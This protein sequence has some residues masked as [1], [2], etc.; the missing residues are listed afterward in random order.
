M[1]SLKNLAGQTI[2][3]GLSNIAAKL[4]NVLL[5]PL[6]TYILHTPQGQADFGD[7]S[8]LYA[9]ISFANVIYTYGMETAFFRFANLPGVGR[10]KLF[11]TSLG[12]L[13][14]ST[15]GLSA[16]LLFF[17]N[18]LAS[19]AGFA[20][21]PEYISLAVLII[22]TD[23]LAAIPFAKLRQDGRPK[24][25]A[26]IR[27]AGILVNIILTVWF[28]ALSPDWVAKHPESSYS[29]WYA[30][31]TNPAL[32]LLAGLG[33]SLT[34]F[35]LLF[36]EWAGFRFQFDRALWKK[37]IVYSAPFI[38]IG[39][40]GMINETLDRIMLRRLYIGDAESAKIAVGIYGANYRISIFI[41]LFIQAFR[42]GAEPFFFKESNDKNAPLTYA[43]VMK[44][45]VITLCVAFLFTALFL[46]L[47][48]YMVGREYRSGLGVVPILLYA[49][50]FLG[51]Y[52]NL[53]VWYKISG[54]L[55]WGVLITLIGAA[56]TLS[57]NFAFIPKYGMYACAWATCICYASMMVLSYFSGQH[58]FPV[59]YPIKKLL[60]YLGAMSLLFV[61]HQGLNMVTINPFFRFAAGAVLLLCFVVLV[62]YWER[63][64]LKAFPIIGRYIR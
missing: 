27:V 19:F 36:Q 62:W 57:L 2:W 10:E 48:K 17:R 29:L 6:L 16:L 5:T 3:Y 20:G 42:M 9:A 58:Y 12:S 53:A 45:F 4:L 38:I 25:Y 54:Q 14:I 50:L 47:W 31:Y 13:I 35:L 40:G 46:D 11:Q 52:Y 34:T 28:I 61:I 64:E 49:N 23:T 60:G 21:H 22:A 51:V 24:K 44:W 7:F 30:Q 18:D 56:I 39:L 8:V 15:L 63:K 59:P 1:A 32:I 26:F 33:G 43:K 37:I 41:T 55:K